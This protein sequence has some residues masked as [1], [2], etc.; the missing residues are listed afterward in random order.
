MKKLHHAALF[1]A[2]M[3]LCPMFQLEA[4][5]VGQSNQL[6]YCWEETVKP[7][8]IQEYMAFYRELIGICE[9]VNYPFPIVTWEARHMVFQFWSP[10]N[11]L[12]DIETIP[13]AWGRVI[14]KFGV[15]KYQSLQNTILY[16]YAKTATILGEL[17]YL[18]AD[19]E[20][21]F[22]ERV[23]CRWIE[24]YLKPG[25]NS[26]L[27]EAM[28]WFNTQ[29]SEHQVQQYMNMARGNLGFEQPD[30]V[31]TYYDVSQEDLDRSFQNVT[32]EF[33]KSYQE[34]LTRIR[35][36]FRKPPEVLNLYRMDELSYFPSGS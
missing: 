31:I 2:V 12:S 3:V 13:E 6:Y 33:S 4:Q 36:I 21:S 19:P 9:E 20:T 10:L 27:I 18:P 28:Q 34:Y 25:T 8:Y 24:I 15:E 35:K 5:D 22:E 29:R 32:D 23:Y 14:E 26:E 7:E 16:K 11:S 17:T 30:Y 1:L